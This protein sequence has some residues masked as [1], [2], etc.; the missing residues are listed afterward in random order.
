[1]QSYVVKLGFGLDQVFLVRADIFGVSF[2]VKYWV[3][4]GVE[5]FGNLLRDLR[6]YSPQG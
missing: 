2:L 1:M 6:V 5:L 4:V 3:F